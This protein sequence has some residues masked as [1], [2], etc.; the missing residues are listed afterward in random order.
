MEKKEEGK[1]YYSTIMLV[2]SFIRAVWIF[3]IFFQS[4]KID[5]KKLEE[6]KYSRY[7]GWEEK[8]ETCGDNKKEQQDWIKIKAKVF[9]FHSNFLFI[10]AID[11]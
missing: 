8:Q 5:E 6:E 4:Q 7:D 11:T 1:N 10:Y 9:L 3:S 2:S